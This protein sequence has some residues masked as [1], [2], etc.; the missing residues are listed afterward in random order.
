MVSNAKYVTLK[1]Y[2]KQNKAH[3]KNFIFVTEYSCSSN[4]NISGLKNECVKYTMSL[5]YVGYSRIAG[6]RINISTCILL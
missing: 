3:R 5:K 4:N 2:M 6:Y 1:K